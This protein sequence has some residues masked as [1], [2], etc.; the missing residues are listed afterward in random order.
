MRP[1]TR[2]DQAAPACALFAIGASLL[3]AAPALSQEATKTLADVDWLEIGLTLLGGLTLFLYGV[4]QLAGRLKALGSDRLKAVLQKGSGDRVRG[5]TSGTVVT[6]LLD[7]SSA[8][9]ILIIALVDSG[10]LKFASA[11]PVILGSNIGTTF[12]SQIFALNADSLAPLLLAFGLLA[13]MLGKSETVKSWS[14]VVFFL[15][16]VLF[17]L[18]VIGLA[19]EPLKDVPE[20]EAWLARFEAPLMGVLA[21]AAATVALQSSSAMM[22]II[23]V[24]A[25]QGLISLEAGLALML[26]A[27]IGTCADTLVAT[28]GRSRPALRAGVFHLSFNLVSVAVGL[29]LLG[30]LAALATA[31]SGVV[32]QQI[33]NAHVAFNVGG[34]VIFL[35]LTPWIARALEW[36]IP[37]GRASHGARAAVT[38]A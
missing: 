13:A 20:V 32:A 11:L 19:A 23:I 10:M 34:A 17:G 31:T 14:W 28:I 4:S 37:D 3:M 35:L 12:S 1:E 5:L 30:P 18:S 38:S 26:G 33:A 27:E 2:L 7:S 15:G 8:V 25:G 22:G 24:L 29:A 6:V 9:I 36:L 21:G 16:L